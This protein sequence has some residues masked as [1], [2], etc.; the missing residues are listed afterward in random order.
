MEI[1]TVSP[2]DIK[3]VATNTAR[4]IPIDQID[5]T[6][7]SQYTDL[8]SAPLGSKILSFSDEWFAAAENLITPTPPI[9]KPGVFT[10]AGAWYDGW[11]TRRHNTEPADWV[12]LRLG[13]ASGK[14]AGVEIDTA[15]FNGNHAPEIAVEGAFI[16]DEKEEE[17]VKKAGY[18]G[19]ETILAKQE[20]G[21]TQRHG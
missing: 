5:A 6:F 17:E 11:E 2:E 20:C 12:V 3:A 19:W 1:R 16:T 7:K 8:I 14:V 4:A 13:T 9:R 15:F 21:P 10:H 18:T